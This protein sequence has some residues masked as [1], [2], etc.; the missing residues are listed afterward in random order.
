MLR[1]HFIV[2]IICARR[3]SLRLLYNLP[4]MKLF[5]NQTFASVDSPL[6]HRHFFVPLQLA[7]L[8]SRVPI[9]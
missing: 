3:L 5:Q 7:R 6:K 2:K 8:E 9:Y 1:T 4:I